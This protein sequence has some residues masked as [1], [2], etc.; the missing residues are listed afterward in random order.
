MLIGLN[1]QGVRSW[2]FSRNCLG[3][4]AAEG[5]WYLAKTPSDLRMYWGPLFPSMTSNGAVPTRHSLSA[6]SKMPVVDARQYSTLM[7]Y[8]F[9]KGL[10]DYFHCLRR[11]GSVNDHFAFLFCRLDV[12]RLR[13]RGQAQR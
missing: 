5:G 9:F 12:D 13:R 2:S 7:P 10:V 3:Y 8:Y 11:H 6:R 4:L 1:R